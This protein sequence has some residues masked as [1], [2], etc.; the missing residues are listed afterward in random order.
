MPEEKYVRPTQ[1]EYFMQIMEAASLRATCDRGRAAA[2]IV[3]DGHVV[4]TGYVGAPAGLEHCDEVGHMMRVVTDPKSG[5]QSEH[6]VR[7]VHAEQNAICQAAKMGQAVKG[8]TLYCRMEPCHACAMMIINC[9]IKRVVAQRQ[10]HAAEWTR[11]MFRQA[12]VQLEVLN[13]EVQ[14]YS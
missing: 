10:Y 5:K 4:A 11:E 12:G 14:E 9:G 3:V 1:D 7:T 2:I 8:G 13:S 6:C